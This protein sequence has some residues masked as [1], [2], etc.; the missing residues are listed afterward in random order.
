MTSSYRDS[1]DK[2]EDDLTFELDR[3]IRRQKQVDEVT[4]GTPQYLFRLGRE[5]IPLSM[6]EFRIIRFLSARPYKAF[7]REQIVK[8]A[9][10]EAQPVTEANLDDHI[11]SLRAKLGM[12]SDYIQTVPYIGF[13]F[14]P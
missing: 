7:P 6:V 5:P 12:F 3:Q 4:G 14:K 13:R 9:D 11:R 10:T 1:F 8:A 2:K